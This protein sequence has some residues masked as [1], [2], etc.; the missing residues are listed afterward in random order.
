MNFR[1]LRVGG[2]LL[3]ST[4]AALI[5]DDRSEAA[6]DDAGAPGVVPPADETDGTGDPPADPPADDEADADEGEGEDGDPAGDP[7]ADEDEAGELPATAADLA[8]F[9]ADREHA[10]RSEMSARITAVFASEHVVGREAAAAELLADDLGSDRIIS[11]LAKMPKGGAG[12]GML[13]GLRGNAN[14]PNLEAGAESQPDTRKA[15][16]SMWDRIVETQN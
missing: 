13:A 12:D 3:A 7:P 11:L 8:A 4:A 14:N 6:A 5:P 1:A 16:A 10:G 2:R 15:N 9:A